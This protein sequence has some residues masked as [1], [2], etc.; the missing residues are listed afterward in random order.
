VAGSVANDINNEGQVVGW[1]NTTFGYQ[2]AFL[3]NNG[4]MTDLGTLGGLSSEAK[5]IN[6]QGQV[7]GWSKAA[8]GAQH[9]FLYSNGVMTDLG[10]LNGYENWNYTAC[11]INDQ[12][13]VVGY[14]VNYLGD[15]Q[16]FL[17]SNGTMT[18]LGTLGK[19][20]QG[21][22]AIGGINKQGQVA[23]TKYIDDST[24]QAC[25]YNKGYL[26]SLGGN[27][28][29]AYDINNSGQVVG[30]SFTAAPIQDHG[31]LYS[32]G[33][34]TD[35]GTLG[36]DL[37]EAYGINDKGQVVGVSQTSSDD[38][39]AF[40]Y[41]DGVMTDL[42]PQGTN[43]SYANDINDSGQVVGYYKT[44]YSS[45]THAFLYQTG[46]Y[47]RYDFKYYYNDGSGDYYTG[48]VFAPTSFKIT[49]DTDNQGFIEVGTHLTTEP[50]GLGSKALNGY[51]EITAITDGYNSSYDK[52][53]YITAYYD[54][55][56]YQA[57][58]GVNSDA[59]ATAGTVYVADR[60]A[61]DESG[62]VVTKAQ[63]GFSAPYETV[64]SHIDADNDYSWDYQYKIGFFEDFSPYDSADGPNLMLK[65]N[66]QFTGDVPGAS[67]LTNWLNGIDNAWNEK[68]SIQYGTESYPIELK[69]EW[70]SSGADQTVTFHNKTDTA[71]DP[72]NMSNWYA[73]EFDGTDPGVVAAHEVG[74]ML[75]QYDEYST[76]AT[77][78]GFTDT[79]TLMADFGSVK[80]RY[81]N[82]FL[83]WLTAKS[84]KTG[85]SL[86]AYTAPAPLI[87][88]GAPAG[89][90]AYAETRYAAPS[91][92]AAAL[93]LAA[94]PEEALY[95]PAVWWAYWSRT[96]LWEEDR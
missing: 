72:A 55:N 79:N 48:Y 64:S 17:Y 74:H 84:G 5:G 59:S 12:G 50:E 19:F 88:A 4:A 14:L 32:N 94:G 1:S 11:D 42:D 75:A 58:E 81:Y 36:G 2:H 91:P 31:F 95:R 47:S 7:V 22:V 13:Q 20:A 85:L 86:V 73:S 35:V 65:L 15:Q 38:E 87:L 18:D 10:T 83:S 8:S 70:V 49:N 96:T 24:F 90:A 29:Y 27:F 93:T 60:T 76:G 23:V 30:R 68:Y 77:K 61:A 21:F 54:G 52:K 78:G 9:A 41:D 82:G 39:H 43:W 56:L 16:A 89:A 69:N 71:A 3:Y 51:Y 33:V 34:M 92:A 63:I 40:L 26:G 57:S 6:D 80:S 45:T 46:D 37:S 67:L 66:I 62:Y 53:E 28:S 25:I 44:T